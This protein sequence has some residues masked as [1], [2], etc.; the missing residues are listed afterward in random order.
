MEGIILILVICFQSVIEKILGDIVVS[1]IYFLVECFF[2]YFAILTIVVGFT[3]IKESSLKKYYGYYSM[4][5]GLIVI[6]MFYLLKTNNNLSIFIWLEKIAKPHVYYYS[7]LVFMQYIA[8]SLIFSI[9][10]FKEKYILKKNILKEKEERKIKIKEEK[11]KILDKIK[12]KNRQ[13][14][15]LFVYSEKDEF[16]RLKKVRLQEIAE[17]NMGMGFTEINIDNK[18][19]KEYRVNYGYSIYPFVALLKENEI[20]YQKEGIFKLNDIEKILKE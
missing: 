7:F 5:N 17:K 10:S 19:D 1:L 3:F 12:E 9:Y 11:E 14:S 15:I 6:F 2:Y 18:S 20:I 13:F 8:I 4:L 16:L